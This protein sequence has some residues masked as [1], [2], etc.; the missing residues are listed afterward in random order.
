MC[1]IMVLWGSLNRMHRRTAQ[2]RKGSERKRWRLVEEEE[3][4]RV[5]ASRAFRVYWCPPYMATSFQYMGWVILAADNDFPA[6]VS[7][8]Y[9]SRVVWKRIT[10]I[11][12]REGV[13]LWV[14]GFFFKSVVQEV[15]LFGLEI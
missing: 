8:L 6:V 15:F 7:N 4:E 1:D 12:S 10:R 2:C 13:E 9:R 5:V 3:E 14:S 11:L